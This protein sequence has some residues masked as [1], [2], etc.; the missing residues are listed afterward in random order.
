M[1]TQKML[2]V[3]HASPHSNLCVLLCVYNI[4]CMV[5]LHNNKLGLLYLL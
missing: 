4:L 1:K 3:F 2:G 5:C